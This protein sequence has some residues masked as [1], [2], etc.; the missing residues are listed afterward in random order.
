MLGDRDVCSRRAGREARSDGA[1]EVA[2][3]LRVE[4]LATL[5]GTGP[6]GFAL[7]RVRD[8]LGLGALEGLLLDQRPLTLVSLA[9]RAPADHDRRESR[10]PGR[11]PRH[12]R[13]PGR[14]VDE[15]VQICALQAPGTP[16]VVEL[17]EAA[18]EKL[19][20]ALV[21]GALAAAR[22]RDSSSGRSG[23]GRHR[24][25]LQAGSTSRRCACTGWPC[26]G[27]CNPSKHPA[28]WPGRATAA[29]PRTQARCRAASRT[30]APD[31][32]AVG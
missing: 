21:T 26:P 2:H 13:V 1:R 25:P 28:R 30:S 12:C 31:C 29:S 17:N 9:R 6:A 10:L 15:V 11:A 32:P 7:L 23:T 16:L 5:C 24:T 4:T 20:A 18:G 19:R 27:T 22:D 8:A 3:V 14:E